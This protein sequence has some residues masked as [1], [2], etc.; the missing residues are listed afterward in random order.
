MSGAVIDTNILYDVAVSNDIPL[1]TG[2]LKHF[3]SHPH[4]LGV[5]AFLKT[6]T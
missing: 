5:A 4:I 3:P 2:N 1:V 6:V